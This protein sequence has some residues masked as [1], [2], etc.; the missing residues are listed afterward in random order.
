MRV[1]DWG[2]N[3][4]GRAGNCRSLV[5][6][7]RTSTRRHIYR[8]N[9]I[10]FTIVPNFVIQFSVAASYKIKYLSK[11]SVRDYKVQS[12]FH[13]VLLAYNAPEWV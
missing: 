8:T 2:A 5:G 9:V 1:T 11:L 7:T 13:Q 10:G 6:E 12:I 3:D 4:S